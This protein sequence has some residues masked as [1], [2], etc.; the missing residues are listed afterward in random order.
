MK[1]KFLNK[2]S[3][4]IEKSVKFGKGVVVYPNNVL[5]GNTVIG[6]ECILFPN[7]VIKS[8][9][10]GKKCEI[11]ASF[12]ESSQIGEK[13][14]IGPFANLREQNKVGKE[15]KIGDFVELKNCD[16][17]DKTKASHH[18]YLGDITIGKR[19]NIGAGVIVANYDGTKKH[20]SAIGDDVFVGCNSN[21]ISP[22][23]VANNTYI[24]AGTTLTKNTSE[25][26]FVIARVRETFKQRKQ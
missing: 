26:D 23:V 20:N 9:K 19:C 13:T 24:C 12:L 17:G 18:A 25:N 1:V 6:D 3:C 11:K 14:T 10:I 21:L 7:N 5:L 16:M 8:C 22:I 2:K 4:F 15:C